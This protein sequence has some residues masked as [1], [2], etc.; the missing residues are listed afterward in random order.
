MRPTLRHEIFDIPRVLRG[1]LDKGRR[2]Y[3]ETLRR[4]LGGETPLTFVGLE[5]TLAL[6][7]CTAAGFASLLEWPCAVRS[8]SEMD[9][10]ARAKIQPRSVFFLI[11]SERES[12]ELAELARDVRSRHGLTLALVPQPESSL[13]RAADGAFPVFMGKQPGPV[14]VPICQQAVAGY[15]ALIAARALKRPHARFAT[16]EKE[17]DELPNHIEHAFSQHSEGVR[18]LA[19]ELTRAR[20]L[21]VLGEGNYRFAAIHAADLLGSLAGI[22]ARPARVTDGTKQSATPGSSMLVLSGSRCRS[23]TEIQHRVRDARRTGAAVF[24]LTDGN[25]SEVSRHS[26]MTLLLPAL[27]EITGAVLAHVIAAWIA[28]EASRVRLRDPDRTK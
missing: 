15:L 21:T 26:R 25:D 6:A 14:S 2:E 20:N 23:R 24:S 5:A 18:S 10:A 22:S 3:D 1:I 9:A 17:F 7:E 11:E 8:V 27:D 4:G 19:R 13:V 16:L 12:V 28:Y